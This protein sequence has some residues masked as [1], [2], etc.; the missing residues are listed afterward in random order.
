LVLF[1]TL[2]IL[3]K[4]PSEGFKE[5]MSSNWY[6]DLIDRTFD[7]VYIDEL[8]FAQFLLSIGP[9]PSLTIA[10]FEDFLKHFIDLRRTQVGAPKKYNVKK[11]DVVTWFEN[12][13]DLNK[14][15][16]ALQESDLAVYSV[17]IIKNDMPDG[18]LNLGFMNV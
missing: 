5:I 4:E 7:E 15:N 16:A 18:K 14:D 17:G 12:Y 10:V 11:S 6:T 3:K 2:S 8:D 9:I 13:K 1:L